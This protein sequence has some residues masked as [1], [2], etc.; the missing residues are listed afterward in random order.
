VDDP[1]GGYYLWV[2]A[3]ARLGLATPLPSLSTRPARGSVLVVPGEAFGPAGAGYLRLSV[4][5][6]EA[7]V[8]AGMARLA[9]ALAGGVA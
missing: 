1:L 8:D 9:R 7:A 2:D 5:A 6:G 4:A 3:R